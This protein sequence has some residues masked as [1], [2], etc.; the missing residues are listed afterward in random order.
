M[1]YLHSVYMND[2]YVLLDARIVAVHTVVL[3]TTEFNWSSL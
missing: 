2:T 3:D 1:Q